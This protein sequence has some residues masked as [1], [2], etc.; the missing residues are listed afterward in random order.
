MDRNEDGAG[1]DYKN[2][3]R[4]VGDVQ[5]GS[6][7]YFGRLDRQF[8]GVVKAPSTNHVEGGGNNE[9]VITVG[10]IGLSPVMSRWFR[11][12]LQV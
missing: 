6:W 12:G 2:A 11:L 4:M 10:S 1:S 8:G 5:E 7:G 3:K 9:V